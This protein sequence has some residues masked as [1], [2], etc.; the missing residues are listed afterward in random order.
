[1]ASAD[2]VEADASPT[3]DAATPVAPAAEAADAGMSCQTTMRSPTASSCAA[4]AS[5]VMAPSGERRRVL[6][7]MMTTA[8]Y[9]TPRLGPDGR[10]RRP[11]Q[12]EPSARYSSA[13]IAAI[14]GASVTSPGT[15][16]VCGGAM[17]VKSW[18]VAHVD[19]L[20][21]DEHLDALRGHQGA[22]QQT[23]QSSEHD[24]AGRPMHSR[25]RQSSRCRPGCR[26]SESTCLRARSSWVDRTAWCSPAGSLDPW[27]SRG[28]R[29]PRH[30][31]NWPGAA[32]ECRPTAGTSGACHSHSCRG[33]GPRT[34]YHPR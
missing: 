14:Y 4:R 15:W 7:R 23:S 33:T 17:I 6:H 34:R 1:M 21:R 5:Q 8:A 3:S 10:L 11:D 9:A 29:D 32:G 22:T 19:R 16:Q 20:E 30:P 12:L 27:C 24:R 26:S 13:D 2:P 31:R 25:S 18:P 28:G